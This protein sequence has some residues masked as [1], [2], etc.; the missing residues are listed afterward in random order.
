MNFDFE[1]SR[2]DCMSSSL[3]VFLLCN[4]YVHKFIRVAYPLI[5]ITSCISVKVCYLSLIVLI[6]AE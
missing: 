2:V 1:I 6:C 5:F 4:M 3:L